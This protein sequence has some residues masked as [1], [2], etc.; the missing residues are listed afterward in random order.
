MIGAEALHRIAEL[1]AIEQQIR[2]CSAAERQDIRDTRLRSLVDALKPWLEG[3]LGRV[4]PRGGLAEA[5]RYALAR[6]PALCR[7]LGD[8]RIELDTNA[9]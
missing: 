2:G 6:W 4:S 7:F 9:V 1:Y 3:Q 8:G 5:L